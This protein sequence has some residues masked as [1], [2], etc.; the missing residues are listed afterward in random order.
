MIARTK[1]KPV[2]FRTGHAIYLAAGGCVLVAAIFM[3][4]YFGTWHLW[5]PNSS[6]ELELQV[7]TTDFVQTQ[8]GTL[9]LRGPGDACRAYRYDN[10]TSETFPASGPC[11]ITAQIDRRIM[12]EPAGAT[13]QLESVSKYFTQH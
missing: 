11:E 7:D 1:P 3:S 13:R 12:G 6:P 8:I 5:N 2:A 9:V 4:S 10:L